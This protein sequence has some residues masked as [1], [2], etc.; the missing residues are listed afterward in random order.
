MLKLFGFI[1]ITIAMLCSTW[2]LHHTAPLSTALSENA[3]DAYMDHVTAMILD[4]TGNPRIKI[5][6]PK[7]MH[8]AKDDQSHFLHPALTIYRTDCK[9]WVVTSLHAEAI[10]GM[11]EINFW[12]DVVLHHASDRKGPDT[13]IKTPRLT[14]YT[15]T[16]LATTQDAITLIQ[17]DLISQATGMIADMHESRIQLLSEAR[18]FYTNINSNKS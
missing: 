2:F 1:S 17:P 5:A 8:Y 6:S 7:M 12:Q 14:V 11:N 9:P 18:A 16:Q 10:Q 3:P 15:K 4:K 13:V